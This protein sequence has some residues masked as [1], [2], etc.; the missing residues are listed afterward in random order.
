VAT[1]APPIT[2]TIEIPQ[3]SP[4]LL[5]LFFFFVSNLLNIFKEGATQGIGFVN[6]TNLITYRPIATGN[7]KTLKKAYN[8]YIK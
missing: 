4:L 5:I 7:C 6:N 2:I 8:T 3:R 1:G